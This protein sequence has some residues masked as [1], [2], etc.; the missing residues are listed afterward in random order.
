MAKAADAKKAIAAEFEA[1]RADLTKVVVAIKSMTDAVAAM[2]Q[3][4][5]NGGAVDDKDWDA[6]IAGGKV[7]QDA[8]DALVASFPAEPPAEPPVSAVDG[9]M[10]PA[11]DATTVPGGRTIDG[12]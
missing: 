6:V 11:T 5:A 1:V 9:G 4:I 2:R 3:Q 7:V 10:N 8:A 12:K